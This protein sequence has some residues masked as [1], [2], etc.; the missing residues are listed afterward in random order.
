MT[1]TINNNV[2]LPRKMLATE[3]DRLDALLDG[4]A[5]NL[6]DAVAMAVKDTVGQVVREA[7]EVAVKEVLSN[8]ELLR[9]ALGQ[10]TSPPTQAQPTAA[11]RQRPSI[12]EVIKRGWSWACK[13]V[14]QAATHVKKKLG[15]GLAWCV[16][17]LRQGCAALRHG[18]SRLAA[19]SV[20]IMATLGAVSVTLWRLR[21][22]CSI[23]LSVGLIAGVVG[24]FAGPIVSSMLCG[25]SGMALTLSSMILLPLWRLLN[26]NISAAAN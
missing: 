24:Y 15:Q 22:S 6:N 8:P 5:E 20:S 12:R 9:A 16:D 18:P 4:L 11:T 10:H 1:S 19:C 7:V 13:K 21:R 25:L 17:K 3:I 23:A 26:W 2:R 14:T